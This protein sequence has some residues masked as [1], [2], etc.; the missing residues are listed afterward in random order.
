MHQASPKLKYEKYKLVEFCQFLHVKASR[1]KQ[2]TH[3]YHTTKWFSPELTLTITFTKFSPK[4][5]LIITPEDF[6]PNSQSTITSSC[7]HLGTTRPPLLSRWKLPGVSVPGVLVIF[8]ENLKVINADKCSP[9]LAGGTWTSCCCFVGGQV[10]QRCLVSEVMSSIKCFGLLPQVHAQQ[11]ASLFWL[12]Q[13]S[14]NF[15]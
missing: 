1:G 4:L 13:S 6:H 3:F 15:P 12:S 9:S 5:S 7:F 14:R 10:P 11:G 8:A 2:K